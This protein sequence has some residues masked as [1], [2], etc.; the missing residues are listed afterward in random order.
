MLKESL[1]IVSEAKL[2]Y[3]KRSRHHGTPSFVYRAES[4]NL[5]RIHGFGT[6]KTNRQ[7]HQISCW[8][9][10]LPIET[11]RWAYLY[12]NMHWMKTLKS[13]SAFTNW[14]GGQPDNAGNDEN[15]IE[16]FGDSK[17]EMTEHVVLICQY[18]NY[19]VIIKLHIYIFICNLEN[20]Y[21]YIPGPNFIKSV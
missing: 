1:Q 8:I 20:I 4:C 3:S 6:L 10:K 12:K 2:H 17:N 16:M 15:W 5:H 9:P 14:S 11:G 19:T 21:N 7:S 18:V 13:M